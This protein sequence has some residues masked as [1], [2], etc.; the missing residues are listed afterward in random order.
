VEA[1]LL[2][3]RFDIRSGACTLS[4]GCALLWVLAQQI[5][6]VKCICLIVL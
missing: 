3:V 2:G 4:I 6:V 1:T 5:N